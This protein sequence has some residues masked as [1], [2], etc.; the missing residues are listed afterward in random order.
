MVNS[1]AASNSWFLMFLTQM[2]GQVVPET[3]YCSIAHF[4]GF[5]PENPWSCRLH[6]GRSNL[7]PGAFKT[8]TDGTRTDL[9][10]PVG[11]RGLRRRKVGLTDIWWSIFGTQVLFLEDEILVLS[12]WTFGGNEYLGNIW[13]FFGP[14]SVHGHTKNLQRLAFWNT[15]QQAA[16]HHRKL[17]LIWSNIFFGNKKLIQKNLTAVSFHKTYN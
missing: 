16:W 8:S 12:L 7:L 4:Q 17:E 11:I 15:S 6:I 1:V 13:P 14:I 3:I 2:W 5:A 9:E 10:T